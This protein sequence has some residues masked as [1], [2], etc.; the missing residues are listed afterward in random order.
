MLEKHGTQKRRSWRV[1]QI[2]MGVAGSRIVAATLTGRGVDD[3]A[4]AGSLLDQVGN[5]VASLTGDGAPSLPRFV[6]LASI[7]YGFAADQ[8]RDGIRG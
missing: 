2:G 1:L 6:V 7:G 4:Q 3:A 8:R 5:P